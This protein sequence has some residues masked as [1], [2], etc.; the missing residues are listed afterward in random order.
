MGT[1]N[2]TLL[3]DALH[4][5]TPFRGMGANMALRDAAALRRALVNVARGEALLLGALAD[6]NEK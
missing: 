3:G 5:M 2:V 1:R 6:T 4:N